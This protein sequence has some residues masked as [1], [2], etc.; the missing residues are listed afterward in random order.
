VIVFRENVRAEKWTTLMEVPNKSHTTKELFSFSLQSVLQSPVQ[1]RRSYR[2]CTLFRI[3]KLGAV[4]LSRSLAFAMA[5]WHPGFVY[6]WCKLLRNSNTMNNKHKHFLKCLRM[7]DYTRY[8]EHQEGLLEI[9]AMIISWVVSGVSPFPPKQAE[10]H[11]TCG[12]T[13]NSKYIL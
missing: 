12:H 4:S 11:L 2:P 7:F 6:S 9:M 8:R 1:S 10:F 3:K 13:A 5:T